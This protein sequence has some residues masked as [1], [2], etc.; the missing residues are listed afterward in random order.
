MLAQQFGA[1]AGAEPARADQQDQYTQAELAAMLEGCLRLAADKKINEKNVWSLPLLEYLPDLVSS[2]R[3][4]DASAYNF[5]KATVGLDAGVQ[6]YEKR[7]DSAFNEAM[8]SMTL[9]PKAAQQGAR[10]PGC[11]A[12][13]STAQPEPP[14]PFPP[15]PARLRRAA[16]TTLQLPPAPRRPAACA[17]RPL[18][19]PLRRRG[20]RGG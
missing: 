3:G 10:R 14:P 2:Q 8:R 11:P 9:A 6:I 16:Q 17:R 4:G 5:Q 18:R 20:G 12:Q 1:G 15:P 19:A 7:V 13:N